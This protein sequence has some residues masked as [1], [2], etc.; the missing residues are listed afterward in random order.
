VVR[1]IRSKG[2]G[3]YFVTQSPADIPDSVLG[4]L[5]NRVQHA[6][7]AYTPKERKAVR[8]AA[9]SFRENPALDTARVI[10][11]LGVGE[12]L[13]STLQDRGVPSMVQRTLIR[14]PASR[15]G[16]ATAAERRAV[17][18]HDPNQRIYATAV[19]RESAHEQLLARAASKQ[20]DLD[21]RSLRRREQSARRKSGGSSS[22][23]STGEAF[24]KSMARSLGSAAGS[25]LGKK[26][27]RG[28]LGSLLR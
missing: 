8:I 28:L 2:V 24:V 9:Q 20:A 25:S 14:P 17:L 16:K 7:R 5:G 26:L 13:V 3:V 15:I 18:E 22:R 1:L 12:A 10:S 4:Q 19:D 21:E 11:E 27:F 23:Q 6:L